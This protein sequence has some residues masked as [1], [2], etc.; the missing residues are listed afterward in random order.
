MRDLTTKETERLDFVHNSVHG[1]LCEVAGQDIEEDIAVVSEIS[2]LAEEYIC[3][4]LQLMTDYEFAPYV[5]D[6]PQDHWRLTSPVNEVCKQCCREFSAEYSRSTCPHCKSIN[7]A[8][9]ACK[10]WLSEEYSGC[11]T[12]IDGCN[13]KEGSH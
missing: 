8:C 4:K 2:D 10:S 9:H 12:C 1:M 6:P 3:N 7:T 5:S 13:F 11:P